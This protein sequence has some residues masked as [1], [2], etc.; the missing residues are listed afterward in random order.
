MDEIGL[1]LATELWFIRHDYNGTIYDEG[2]T[3][4]KWY[5]KPY[6]PPLSRTTTNG[7]AVSETLPF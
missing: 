7:C 1:I 3:Y 5:A 4:S 2:S 6:T